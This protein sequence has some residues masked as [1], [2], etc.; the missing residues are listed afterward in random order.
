MQRIGKYELVEEVGRGAMGIVYR[1]VDPVLQRTVALKV[2]RF[3]EWGDGAMRGELE[4]R[5]LREAR[6][7]GQLSH[8]GIVTVYDIGYEGGSAYIAMEFVAG[9]NLEDKLRKEG[10]LAPEECCRILRQTASALDYAH[11]RGVVHRDVKPGNILLNEQGQVK[12]SDFGIAK[13][14]SQSL[15]QL[16]EV[17]GTPLY[18][19]PEQIAGKPVDARSDQFSLGVVAYQM[20][21]GE[22]PFAGETMASLV[23]AIMSASPAAASSLREGLPPGADEVMARVLAKTPEKRF[24]SCTEFVDALEAALKTAPVERPEPLEE[25]RRIGVPARPPAPPLALAPAAPAPAARDAPP[26]APVHPPPQP[27]GATTVRLHTLADQTP[28][29]FFNTQVFRRTSFFREEGVRFVEIENTFKFYRDHLAEEF[30]ILSRQATVTYYLWVGCVAVGFLML[31]AGV[32][33][34]FTKGL[35]H[36]A[37]TSASTILVYFIQ[38]VFHQREDHYRAMASTKLG[39]LEYGNQWLLAIQ[40]IDAIE[41]VQERTR[42]QGLLVDVLTV[43]LEAKHS[44]ARNKPA[45]KV[46]AARAK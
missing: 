26:S 41:D 5:F 38:R 40:T 14:Q 42:R 34:M 6:T 37:V 39:H 8:P 32:V 1:C 36:G 30:K 45:G 27:A 3:S 29:T 35:A 2:V 23:H 12:L 15:T 43:K 19:S 22:K 25:T 16:G 11:S 31:L 21:T 10:K 18:M 24:A 13:I 4:Q 44:G 7:A 17:F 9:T 46:K 33:L 20:L 28:G